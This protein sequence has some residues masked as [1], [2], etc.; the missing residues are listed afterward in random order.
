MEKR[1]ICMFT[2]AS[3]ETHQDG[4][5]IFKE[6]SSGDWVYVILSGSVEISKMVEGKKVVVELLEK[7]QVFGELGFLE[8]IKRTATAT[9]VGETVVG[10]IDR[11]SLDAEFNHLSSGFRAIIKA[12][13]ERHKK[14][15]DRV[16]EK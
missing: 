2:I 15:L 4:Q 5:V 6:G 11:A 16:S 14:L 7:D 12:I 3:E 10:L 8:G 13:V 1:G 9:T